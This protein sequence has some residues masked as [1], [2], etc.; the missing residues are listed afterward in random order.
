MTNPR[1][2]LAELVTDV[3]L[4]KVLDDGIVQIDPVDSK[5]DADV[6]NES[7]PIV[8]YPE[9]DPNYHP[10]ESGPIF[11]DPEHP[12]YGPNSDYSWGDGASHHPHH[13]HHGHGSG[14]H[15]R[16]APADPPGDDVI[17]GRWGSGSTRETNPAEGEVTIMPVEEAPAESVDITPTPEPEPEPEM[18]IM[19]V[20]EAPVTFE[21]DYVALA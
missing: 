3:D 12:D 8:Y 6:P 18:S 19:P 2:Y 13:P 21:A 10:N 5:H 9:D 7:G 15:H 4:A 1:D 14:H 11:Y 16:D 20:E 17:D